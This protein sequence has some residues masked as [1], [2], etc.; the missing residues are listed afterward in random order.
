MATG[1]ISRRSSGWGEI[2][3]D[4][5]EDDKPMGKKDDE[6]TEIRAEDVSTEEVNDKISPS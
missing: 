3:G 6:K 1:R 5:S 2:T 4:E